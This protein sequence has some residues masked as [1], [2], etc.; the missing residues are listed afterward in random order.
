MSDS[1]HTQ[2]GLSSR[3]PLP[4]L[5]KPNSLLVLLIIQ[6]DMFDSDTLKES[7]NFK[8]KTVGKFQQQKSFRNLQKSSEL[9]AL[10]S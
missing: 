3:R 9:T 7:G 6:S 1:L 2:A 5:C 8:E 4:A 10:K